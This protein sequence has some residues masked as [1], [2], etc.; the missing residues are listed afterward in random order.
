MRGITLPNFA[1]PL[2]PS[3]PPNAPYHNVSQALTVLT[4]Q[5]EGLWEALDALLPGISVE[6]V[7][8]LDS[9]NTELMR[10]VRA[11]QPYPVLLVALEQ[12]AG[13]GRRGRQWVS[14]P[15]ASLTLSLGLPLAPQN[16]SGLSLV[17]GVSLAEALHPQV[18]LKWP[19]D[20]WWQGRKLGGILVE[21]ASIGPQ[22]YAVIGLGL[23]VQ[24][25]TSLPPSHTTDSQAL[26]PVPPAG[27][28]ELDTTCASRDAGE[29]LT[30]LAPTLLRDVLQFQQQGLAP[31]LSRFA[32]RDAL[33]G[34][35][36]QLSDGQSGT[37]A[38]IGP[39]GALWLDTAQGRVA[40]TS[41]EVS[42]RPC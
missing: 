19:N 2:L 9:T 27:L 29:W 40:V 26:A 1:V 10:R 16:W 11:G 34:V 38:G 30:A 37:A 12:T 31:F 6:V 4:R 3:P 41:A 20:L 5:A 36:V 24:A 39:D 21:T 15:G 13:K 33:L 28:Q 23:N 22:R 14:V 7:P 25:P 32:T 35:A 8:T 18:Q 42:V 17:V